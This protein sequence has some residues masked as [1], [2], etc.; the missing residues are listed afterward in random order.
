MNEIGP[1]KY[2]TYAKAIGDG[3][4]RVF[5]YPQY[6]VVDVTDRYCVFKVLA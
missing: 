2:D 5:K 4:P 6:V 1:I 3:V